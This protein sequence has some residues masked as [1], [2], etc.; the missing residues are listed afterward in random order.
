LLYDERSRSAE[1]EKMPL[2]IS[3][4]PISA[5][6]DKAMSRAITINPTKSFYTAFYPHQLYL[7]EDYKNQP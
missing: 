2:Q 4:F 5:A 1:L 6:G 3:I 7:A